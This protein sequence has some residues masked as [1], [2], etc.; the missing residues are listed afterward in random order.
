MAFQS[1]LLLNQ[2]V[3]DLAGGRLRITTG[4]RQDDG[5]TRFSF[6]EQSLNLKLVITGVFDFACWFLLLGGGC[7]RNVQ[8][9]CL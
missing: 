4:C 2:V 9:Q 5:Q 8:R 3:I 1:N 6:G 7:E